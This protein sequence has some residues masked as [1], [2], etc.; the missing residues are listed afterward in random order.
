MSPQVTKGLRF[1]QLGLFAEQDGIYSGFK[2]AGNCFAC[3]EDVVYSGVTL[4]AANINKRALSRKEDFRLPVIK[5]I[6]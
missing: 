1:R 2:Q 5:N 3:L 6:L 4:D